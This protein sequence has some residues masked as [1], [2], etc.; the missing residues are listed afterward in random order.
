M[1]ND[2]A[3]TFAPTPTGAAEPRRRRWPRVLATVVAIVLSVVVAFRSWVRHGVDEDAPRVG[4]VIGDDW[5]NRLGIHQ[6]TY[7]AVITH[8]GGRVV[9]LDPRDDRSADAILDGVD[10]LVLTGGGDVDPELSGAAEERCQLVDRNRD[11]FEIALVQRALERD[12]P[13]LAVCRGHQLLNV[14]FGGTLRDL[15][16]D[17]EMR[18]AHSITLRSLDAH[19]VYVT[20]GS[21]LDELLRAPEDVAPDAGVPLP[22]NSFHGQAVDAVAPGLRVS[23]VSPDGVIEALEVPGERYAISVQWHPEILY[24]TDAAS[25]RLFERLI[26]EA[27]RRRD[28]RAPRAARV[29]AGA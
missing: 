2:T 21:G 15:R 26:E 17:P 29:D 11:D 23:A 20:P 8:A 7:E 27:E 22:V 14:I 1:S 16:G 9:S 18:K 28:A 5:M 13:I 6:A 24:W 10:A 3:A 4:M 19:G 25:R 12:I